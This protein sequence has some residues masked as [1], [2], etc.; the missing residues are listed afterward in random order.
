M[1]KGL[2]EST[3]IREM[4]GVGLDGRAVVQSLYRIT[5]PKIGQ[6]VGSVFVI[7]SLISY[8]LVLVFV[9]T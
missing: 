8:T 5:Q 1:A 7:Q 3:V 6:L 2:V 9:G 4:Y